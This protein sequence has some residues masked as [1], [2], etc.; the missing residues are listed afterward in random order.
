M[1][2]IV[3]ATSFRQ[4]QPLASATEEMAAFV[5]RAATPALASN[6]EDSTKTG[7]VAASEAPATGA[8][9]SPT[10]LELV[11]SP[12]ARENSESR[13]NDQPT[14]MAVAAPPPPPSSV[15]ASLSPAKLEIAPSGPA[16]EGGGWR[17]KTVRRTD[18]RELRKQTFYLDASISRRL[19][20]H[21]SRFQYEQ[22]RAVERAVLALLESSG[23]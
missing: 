20:Q 13:V 12:S 6:T 21:C 1:P 7:E 22:S 17:S 8:A 9:A 19:T 11:P 10:K 2:K 16:R 18:G 5:A 3:P 4:V 15:A 23:D 14:P